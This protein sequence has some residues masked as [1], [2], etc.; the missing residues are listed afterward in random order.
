MKTNWETGELNFKGNY[1]PLALKEVHW[2]IRKCE[3]STA[4]WN[5]NKDT[6]SSP[7]KGLLLSTNKT[8]SS[9]T[10][11]V[12]SAS[13]Q[14]V[15]NVTRSGSDTVF[16]MYAPD[17]LWFWMNLPSS[18]R[19]SYVSLTERFLRSNSLKYSIWVRSPGICLLFLI[20]SEFIKNYQFT[21]CCHIK[22][23]PVTMAWRA[24]RLRMEEK[25]SRY[26][27]WLLMYWIS[28][29]GQPTRGDPPAWGLGVG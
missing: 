29:C 11:N 16:K 5:R 20:F 25:I 3:N 24:L 21:T 10:H 12:S 27:G 9:L 13:R 1:W 6:P 23:V 4:F 15:A 22:W 26:G 7:L 17:L 19:T 2:G 18:S 28:S 14:N 8:A